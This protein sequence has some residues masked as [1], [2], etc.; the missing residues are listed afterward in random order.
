ML[1]EHAVVARLFEAHLVDHIPN[2]LSVDLGFQLGVG[3]RVAQILYEVAHAA[4]DSTRA[5]DEC[6]LA[7]LPLFGGGVGVLK[8]SQIKLGVDVDLLLG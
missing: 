8:R 4:C 5:E 1:E 7:I 6:A 2:V 3:H